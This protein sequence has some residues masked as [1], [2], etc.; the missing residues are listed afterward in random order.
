MVTNF[1]VHKSFG[2][3]DVHRGQV[4]I[5]L[6]TSNKVHVIFRREA[7]SEDMREGPAHRVLLHYIKSRSSVEPYCTAQGI[8]CVTGSLC[9]TVGI[10]EHCK[11]TML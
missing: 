5:F 2:L 10:E 1:L 7:T 9:C 8:V 11:S 4:S 6:K 3:V